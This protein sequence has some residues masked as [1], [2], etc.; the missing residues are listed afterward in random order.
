MSKGDLETALS[1]VSK[2]P[3]LLRSARSDSLIEF[4]KPTRVEP[5][6]LMDDRVV[7]LSFTSDIMQSLVSIFSAYYL[8]AVS[9]S[10]NVGRVDVIGLLDKINPNRSIDDNLIKGA[11]NFGNLRST[12]ESAD[13]YAYGLPVPGEAVGLECFGLEAGVYDK[14]LNAARKTEGGD[15]I[16]DPNS[17]ATLGLG[18]DTVKLA[19]DATNLSVGKLL[20]VEISDGTNKAVFPIGVRLIVTTTPPGGIVHT[21]SIGSKDKSFKERWHGWRSGQLEFVRDLVLAQDLIDAHKEGLLKDTSGMYTQSLKR[22]NKN[23][24]SA[25]LSGNPSVATASNIIVFA[26]STR[27]ELERNIG[28]RLK[29]FRTREKVFKSTYSMLMVVVDPEWENVTIYHR[30]IESPTELSAGDLKTM[31]RGKG[32]DVAEILKAYTM[33]TSPSF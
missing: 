1:L 3:D 29:D 9:L 28:G 25:I 8:Q 11:T 18:K 15:P 27:K 21:L 31:N 14:L 6:C 10:V 30:S 26:D 33:G 2:M 24:I 13:A 22:R 16:E 19:M 7:G 4:T 5:I 17:N 20:E 23:V 12:F 32:P